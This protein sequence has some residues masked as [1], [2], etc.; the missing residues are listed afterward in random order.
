MLN[1][2][3]K[4]ATKSLVL[5]ILTPYFYNHKNIFIKQDIIWRSLGS[6]FKNVYSFLADSLDVNREL[7]PV[8]ESFDRSKDNGNGSLQT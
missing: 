2:K 6:Q 4:N 8:P 1:E 5:C 3:H 7:S